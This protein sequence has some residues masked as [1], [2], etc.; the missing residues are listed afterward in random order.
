M[1]SRSL[2]QQILD[3]VR[4]HGLAMALHYTN[5]YDQ[6]SLDENSVVWNPMADDAVTISSDIADAIQYA[7]CRITEFHE[8]TLPQSVIMDSEPGMTLRERFVPIPRVGVYVPNGEYPLISSAL[9]SVIPARVAGVK[10]IVVSIPPRRDVRQSALWRYVLQ[11]LEIREVLLLGGAQAIAALGYGFAGFSPV[12]LIAGPGNRFVAEAKQ[13]MAL[14][15]IVGL[16]VLA[17]PS[18]VMIVANDPFWEDFVVADLFTQA[19]HALDAS[20]EFLTT[21]AGLAKSV[22]ERVQLAPSGMGTIRVTVLDTLE[23]VIAHVN[24]VAPEHLGLMGS[25]IESLADRIWSAGAIFIGP[26]SGQ[27]LGDYVAGPSHVLPTGGAGRFLS[28]LSTRTFLKRISVIQ[29]SREIGDE[30]YRH[31]ACLAAVEGLTYHQRAM[32]LRLTAKEMDL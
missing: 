1:M 24:R 17:G 18:E 9:M 26:W 2:V 20:A 11:L 8:R 29:A 16:D 4:D 10:D 15:G 7:V 22:K 6:V 25:D 28:G 19:E 30:A 5:V 32:L 27:A 31:A 13:E 12:H 14:R 21:N 3:D 23:E